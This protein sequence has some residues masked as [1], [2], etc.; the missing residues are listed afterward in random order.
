MA[1]AVATTVS[2]G[3]SDVARFHCYEFL[4]LRHLQRD[5]QLLSELRQAVVPASEDDEVDTAQSVE[6]LLA[7]NRKRIVSEDLWFLPL[8][9]QSASDRLVAWCRRADDGDRTFHFSATHLST[10]MTAFNFVEMFLDS[11]FRTST[12]SNSA[13]NDV[14][15]MQRRC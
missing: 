1:M 14:S 4:L 3:E 8:A 6:A 11:V 13:G 7:R 10:Y 12:D 2:P 9:V 15:K 5:R